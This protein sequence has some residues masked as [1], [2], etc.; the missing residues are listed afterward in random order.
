MREGRVH[1]LA[2]RPYRRARR[3][4][5]LRPRPAAEGRSRLLRRRREDPRAGR[6]AAPL[7]RRRNDRLRRAEPD[8]RRAGRFARQATRFERI[9]RGRHRPRGL[10]RRASRAGQGRDPRERASRASSRCWSPTSSASPMPTAAPA[11]TRSS[12]CAGPSS[13]SSR[14]FPVYRSYIS[15][16]EPAAR[17]CAADR[18]DD[19]D[20][21]S[22]AAPCPTAACTISSP[23]RSSGGSRPGRPLRPTVRRFRRR[24]QQLTGPVMAKSLEDT[25]FY[26]YGRLIALNEV[27]GD[28]GHFGLS[29]EA[30]H[31][32]NADR[33]PRLAAC[34]DRDGDPRHQARRGCARAPARPSGDAGGMVQGARSLAGARRPSSRRR[35]RRAGARCQRSGASCFRRF[36]AP[37]RSSFWRSADAEQLAAFRERM[38]D[39]LIKALREAKRHTSWVHPNEAYEEAALK[40]LHDGARSAEPASSTRFRPLARR[41]AM[42]GMLNGLSRTV[43]KMHPAGR[44]GHLPGHRVLGL[45]ARRSRQPAAGG[46]RARG[47]SRS[48]E[49]A[50]RSEELM[51]E[52][53]GRRGSSSGSSHSCS[54]TAPSPPSL[55]AEGDYQPLAIEG[56]HT[57]PT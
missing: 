41:L 25:L 35:E 13:R 45:L 26:R 21:A 4:G 50:H 55:Y 57:H 16:G 42:L 46:L 40:L 30:F 6:D 27:G 49:R 38:E 37:G 31:A 54:T 32:A 43:L 48:G 2:H 29:L 15:D 10:L 19:R 47:A 36:S 22:D 8:R 39:Y 18:G 33:A 51:Q 1:G 28:P 34:D 3:S 12:P 24:F 5:G 44:A 56:A 11:T 17:G 14:A 52:L 20:G 53:A 23:R 7:A 9:Y